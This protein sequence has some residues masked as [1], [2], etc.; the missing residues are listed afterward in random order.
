MS[1]RFGADVHLVE[2][3]PELYDELST[4]GRFPVFHCAVTDEEG[5]IRFNLARCDVGSSILT[6]PSESIYDSVLRETVEVP[7]RTVAWILREVGWDRV[8]LIKM[9]IEGAEVRVL[10]SLGPAILDKVGQITIE[11]HGDPVFG[12]GIQHQVEECLKR[13][14]RLG[15]LAIDFTFPARRDVLLIN[16]KLIRVPLV[17]RVWCGL[18]YNPPRTLDRLLRKMPTGVREGLGRW[19][20]LLTGTRV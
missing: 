12:F 14:R 13:M 19:R 8:D 3:N 6:L 4:R 17:N 9:D 10:A 20:K 7:A 5:T 18:M 15:F 2:A 16:T 11:F 1:E